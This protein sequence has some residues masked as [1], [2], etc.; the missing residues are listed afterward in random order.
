MTQYVV[1]FRVVLLGSVVLL[2]SCGQGVNSGDARLELVGADDSAE[3]SQALQ[4][5]QS[6]TVTLATEWLDPSLCK[7]EEFSEWRNGSKSPP[8]GFYTGNATAFPFNPT[9]LPFEGELDV[10]LVFIDWEDLRGTERERDLY[11]GQAALFEDF[12]AMASENTLDVVI[13]PS[14]DWFTIE[15]SYLDFTTEPDDEAQRGEAPKKQVFYDAAIAASDEGFDYGD[16]DIVFFGIP[17]GPSVFAQGLHEFNFD[18]NGF[19]STDEGEIFDIAVAGDWFLDSRGDEPPW[20]Y[21]VHEV[22]HMIGLQHLANEDDR[23]EERTWVRNPMS[24]YD[25][26]A[27][28]GGASRTLSGW[29]RWLP[30]WLTDEQVVCVDRESLSPGS[31][32]IQNINAIEG[33]LELVVVKLSDSMALV[34]ESR[35]FDAHLDRPSP[36][37]K[38][39]VLVYTVDASKSGAQGSQV[40][41]SPRD[42]TQMIPEPSWRSQLELDAMLFP[43]DAVEYDGVRI[44]MTARDGGFDIVTVS[45]A[46]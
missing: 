45:P 32:R 2:A 18:Y 11:L 28:Q 1:F 8:E 40:L 38:D 24:G 35:R 31:Y 17:T 19:L 6:P 27:D 41:L 7:I 46:G 13:H 34:A 25:I 4:E 16:L 20:V 39:G 10:G 5:L 12:Y 33:N 23:T 15:R 42:I 26:M 21:Y 37:E 3:T 14:E 9:S 22:G 29:L 43:G 36:N 44:E 30:G